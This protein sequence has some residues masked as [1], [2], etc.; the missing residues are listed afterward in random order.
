MYNFNSKVSLTKKKYIKKKKKKTQSK[1]DLKKIVQLDL[2][3][4]NAVSS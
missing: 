2:Q 3:V 4:S 1:K